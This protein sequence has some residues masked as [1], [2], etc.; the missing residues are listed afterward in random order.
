MG[1]SSKLFNLRMTCQEIGS[2]LGLTLETISRTLSAFN[3]IG[4]ITVDQRMTGINDAE[5]LQTLRR[6]SPRSRANKINAAKPSERAN[7]PIGV[8]PVTECMDD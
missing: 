1:Y 4:L 3:E 5:A 7:L 8:I 2:Y 6:L